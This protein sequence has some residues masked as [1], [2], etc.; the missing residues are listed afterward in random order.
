DRLRR[1]IAVA[2]ERV[3]VGVALEPALLRRAARRKE[4]AEEGAEDEREKRSGPVA[5]SMTLH[6]PAVRPSRS[7]GF[8]CGP[9]SG[10][11]PRDRPARRPRGPA[12]RPGRWRPRA[13]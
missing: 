9:S 11:T 13:G 10:R 4:E 3:G 2:P 6:A 5:H 12:S 7:P 1:A 8:S